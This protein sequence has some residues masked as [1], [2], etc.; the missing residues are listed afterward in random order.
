[1]TDYDEAGVLPVRTE[2]FN[3][4]G[5]LGKPKISDLENTFSLVRY[6]SEMNGLHLVVRYHSF[7]SLCKWSTP[8]SFTYVHILYTPCLREDAAVKASALEPEDADAE[9][10]RG[11]SGA[12]GLSLRGL[13]GRSLPWGAT[14]SQGHFG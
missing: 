7:A 12:T 3:S 1:M 9:T 8:I 2:A 11:H 4:S 10:S 13:P 5:R 14:A 6:Q